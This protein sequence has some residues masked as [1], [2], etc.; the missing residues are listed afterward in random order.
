MLEKRRGEGV[1]ERRERKD[2]EKEMMEEMGQKMGRNWI[3]N[4]R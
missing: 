4:E 3:K 1:G 2:S